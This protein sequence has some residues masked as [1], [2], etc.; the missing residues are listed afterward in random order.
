MRSDIVLDKCIKRIG[1][2]KNSHEAEDLWSTASRCIRRYRDNFDIE[3]RRRVVVDKSK[4]QRNIGISNRV[5][6]RER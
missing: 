5:N 2:N 1:T 4:E 3:L 6:A